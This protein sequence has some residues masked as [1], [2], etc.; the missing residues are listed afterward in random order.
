MNRHTVVSGLT[1]RLSC[2]GVPPSLTILAFLRCRR[3]SWFFF[4]LAIS[5]SSLFR[6]FCQQLSKTFELLECQPL[7]CPLILLCITGRC[8]S[9]GCRILFFHSLPFLDVGIDHRHVANDL[10]LPLAI[11]LGPSISDWLLEIGH[12]HTSRLILKTLR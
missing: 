12:G 9:I 11:H 7:L 5:S 4:I 8:Q 2:I 10:S 6:A 3:R 1:G